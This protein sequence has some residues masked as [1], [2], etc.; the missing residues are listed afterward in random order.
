ML[1]PGFEPGISDSK[2][3]VSSDTRLQIPP[4]ASSPLPSLAASA[5]DWEKYKQYLYANQRPNTARLALKYGKK[6]SFVLERMDIKDLLI[7]Q[8]AKQRHIMKAL[9][10][11]AKY[12]G[13]YED[14]NRLR[15]QHQLKW[16]STDTL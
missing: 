5:V 12:T 15:R 6:Y 14:W 16:S 2:G 1:R 8:P 9:A 11:L 4:V 3:L 13:M 7:L 10:N